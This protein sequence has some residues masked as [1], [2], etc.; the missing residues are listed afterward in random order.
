[1]KAQ[2]AFRPAS[3]N[4]KL[5]T[6]LRAGIAYPSSG[7]YRWYC[8]V[9]VC[10]DRVRAKR[11]ASSRV[12]DFSSFHNTGWANMENEQNGTSTG[13]EVERGPTPVGSP[14]GNDGGNVGAGDGDGGNLSRPQSPQRN[15]AVAMGMSSD[16]TVS[17]PDLGQG[18]LG[19]EGWRIKKVELACK[20]QRAKEREKA[21]KAQISA[22][23]ERIRL[24]Q[25]E[26]ENN[27]LES[28][29]L[30]R[31][32]ERES[33][34]RE[35]MR[36]DAFIAEKLKLDEEGKVREH[37]FSV[38]IE[39]M[40][41]DFIAR[42]KQLEH[43]IKIKEMQ[44]AFEKQESALQNRLDGVRETVTEVNVS[45]RN[46]NSAGTVGNWLEGIRNEGP[47]YGLRDPRD[48]EYAPV[49]QGLVQSGATMLTEVGI[50]N[51]TTQFIAS[52]AMKAKT[53]GNARGRSATRELGHGTNTQNFAPNV[54]PSNNSTLLTGDVTR[55][56]ASS[57]PPPTTSTLVTGASAATSAGAPKATQFMVQGSRPGAPKSGM[58]AFVLG[59]TGH[60]VVEPDSDGESSVS[61]VKRKSKLRSGMIANPVDNI[62]TQEIW[63]HYNLNFGYI[64]KKV[65]FPTLTYEQYI[66]GECKTMLN[67]N[68]PNE[69]RGRLNLLIRISYLKQK[70]FTWPNLREL[71]AAIVGH[72][73]RHES[74]WISDWRDIEDMVLDT[75]R[76][77]DPTSGAATRQKKTEV[78]FCRNFNR[79]EGCQLPSP[80]EANVGKRRRQ[81]R[82]ICAKCWSVDH[83]ARNHGEHETCCP[84]SE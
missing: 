80:H 45:D 58:D 61:S 34:D 47:G 2:L 40:K 73:E 67:S 82:H 52:Q 16:S 65:E 5:K 31:E 78:W 72:I 24:E 83:E 69:V 1:M 14:S 71:Y 23:R 43:D 32:Q 49:M 38:E 3:G 70:G 84:H 27:R 48:P 20:L 21:L 60:T 13:T 12:S 46:Q 26:K 62:K 79:Q 76:Q 66:A 63:P 8:F 6:S 44:L 75:V 35:Q 25:Q 36:N 68:D 64:V 53:M 42:Q 15:L 18:E 74:T 59:N 39:R 29:L 19:P 9:S 56:R 41:C 17:N 4:I 57:M 55:G 81:V 7:W 50:D 11:V 37:E 28:E 51:N 54:I 10:M 30:L 77:G 33:L 22:Q